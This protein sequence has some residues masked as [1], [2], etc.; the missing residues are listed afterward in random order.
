[1]RT[2]CWRVSVDF[3]T[4]VAKRD[5]ILCFVGIFKNDPASRGRLSTEDFIISGLDKTDELRTI[6]PE[7]IHPTASLNYNKSIGTIIFDSALDPWLNCKFL[8]SE[9]LL[10][11]NLAV[12]N[13]P[14]HEAFAVGISDWYWFKVMMLLKVRISVCIPIQTR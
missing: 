8:C 9:E 14:V 2:N 11:I 13:P 6:Q 10:T 12:Y 3:G 7:I 4:K 5:K 1:M